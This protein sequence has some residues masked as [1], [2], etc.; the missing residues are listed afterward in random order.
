MRREKTKPIRRAARSILEW[1]GT[2]WIGQ[3]VSPRLRNMQLYTQEE[4]EALAQNS[5]IKPGEVREA[6]S[7]LQKLWERKQKAL[8]KKLQAI[9]SE[10]RGFE[11]NRRLEITEPTAKPKPLDTTPAAEPRARG[12]FGQTLMAYVTQ[13]DTL[14]RSLRR[15][16]ITT[17]QTRIARVPTARPS[18]PPRPFAVA[19]ILMQLPTSIPQPPSSTR[20]HQTIDPYD[21]SRLPASEPTISAELADEIL[22]IVRLHAQSEAMEPRYR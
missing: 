12:G 4:R 18:A 7:H 10:I 11:V 16:R 13:L 3:P 15:S 17:R 2:F 14:R 21:Y 9:E 8:L 5:V 1:P 20:T 19:P 22:R 6:P